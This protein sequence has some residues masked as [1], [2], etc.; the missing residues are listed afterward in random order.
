M[1]NSPLP[2]C[3]LPA[4][5]R[6]PAKSVLIFVAIFLLFLIID[7]LG[8]L[9]F[10]PGTKTLAGLGSVFLFGVAASISSCSVFAAGILTA[11]SVEEKGKKAKQALFHIGRLIGF[12]VFGALIGWLG[13]KIS[14]SP[15]GQNLLTFA[16]SVLLFVTGL[17]ILGLLPE[18]LSRISWLSGLKNKLS[19]MT[20][21]SV[22]WMP[23]FL[24]AA[25]FFLPCGFTQS[26]QLYAMSL[27]SPWASATA[28]L[29]FALGT[30]PALLG[31]GL[32]VSVGQGVWHN[33]IKMMAG[34]ITLLL[35]LSGFQNSLTLLGWTPGFQNDN[36]SS[37][38]P[39]SSANEQIIKMNVTGSGYSPNV[40]RVKVGIPV[41]W[42][43]YGS[44]DMGC[45]QG[46]IARSFGIEADLVSGLNELTFIPTKTGNF[47]FSC[48]MG[49]VRGTIVV[50]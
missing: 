1:N 28:M 13:Q 3:C 14:L 8:W 19:S 22:S 34:V 33:R 29:V 44:N 27:A 47:G 21:S 10:S 12:L 49:M 5:K 24:G 7:R 50:E 38:A 20:G 36:S 18:S 37:L 17:K 43:I 11:L 9:V 48:G 2:A 26:A 41:R 6:T 15:A 45:A 32:L 25:T 16:V 39:I 30:L 31:I 40:L 42:Q 23:F 4:K 35:G 46:L